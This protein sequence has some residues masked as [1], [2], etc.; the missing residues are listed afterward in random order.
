MM[1]HVSFLLCFPMIICPKLW[2][3]PPTPAPPLTAEQLTLLHGVKAWDIEFTYSNVDM[4]D[5]SGTLAGLGY[6]FG[7]MPIDGWNLA[8][9]PTLRPLSNLTCAGNTRQ[10]DCS[11]GSDSCLAKY[12]YP[13]RVTDVSESFNRFEEVHFSNGCPGPGFQNVHTFYSVA[14]TKTLDGTGTKVARGRFTIDYST[15]PPLGQ[16]NFSSLG[17][18]DV[19]TIDYAGCYRSDSS[20]FANISTGFFVDIYPYDSNYTGGT[21]DTQVRI[22]NGRFVIHGSAAE[23]YSSAVC[24]SGFLPCDSNTIQP[25]RGRQT[26]RRD[27][28]IREHPDSPIVVTRPTEGILFVSGTKDTI[29]WSTDGVDPWRMLYSIDSGLTYTETADN[30]PASAE[31][32]EWKL[33]DVLS[34]NCRVKVQSMNDTLRYGESD[35]YKMKGYVLTRLTPNGDYEAFKP[36]V[37]GW[38]FAN[39]REEMWTEFED[40]F[41][42]FQLDSV[43]GTYYPRWFEDAPVKANYDDFVSWPLF[44]QTFGKNAC[45]FDSSH[46]GLQYRPSAV[47]FWST[48]KGVWRG[49]CE[50]L[51]LSSAAAFKQKD[52]FLQ[53]FPGFGNF[54]DAFDVPIN[55]TRRGIIN[56][57]YETQFGRDQKAYEH[58]VVELP[59]SQ[60]WIDSLKEIFLEENRT[61]G[62]VL[63]MYALYPSVGH[64]VTPYRL[65]QDSS[66]A[67][68]TKIYVYDSN[69][70]ADEQR[71]VRILDQSIWGH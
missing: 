43:T 51:A 71:Y 47:Q 17:L 2:A 33:P 25:G 10:S 32:Y 12:Q 34:R 65:V 38:P 66:N 56:Q 30:I 13:A 54:G 39:S 60:A 28:V 49:S 11:P 53:K 24:A 4:G 1:R 62:V 35:T 45:Y 48:H 3:Q 21:G 37:H 63:S 41:Y 52:S 68:T 55:I 46:F 42:T 23:T 19:K 16:A 69:H 67:D 7:G 59:V 15:N 44:V 29:G 20:I 27:W 61:D 22:E 26:I 5:G 40:V 6:S 57:L 31:I 8:H 36:G 64:C 50:G 58:Q 18:E 14:G 70:P 9:D